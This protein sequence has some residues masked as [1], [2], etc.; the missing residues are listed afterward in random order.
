MEKISTRVL[1]GVAAVAAA[2]GLTAVSAAA[3]AHAA[4]GQRVS[5]P[6]ASRPLAASGSQL[7]LRHFN[8]PG[9]NADTARAMAVSP[10]GSRVFITGNSGPA[11]GSPSYLT[12]AYNALTGRQLWAARY[13]DPRHGFDAANAVAV[14]PSGGTVF[15]TG[16][17][18][19]ARDSA[20]TYL[21]IAY[22]SS[23]GRQR[24]VARYSGNGH[25]SYDAWHVGGRRPRRWQG[26]RDRPQRRDQLR[27]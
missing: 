15:V 8:G 22:N 1:A 11:N 3:V 7:W 19:P 24:W 21:T 14:G 5:E 13:N 20:S 2:V 27:D 4:G 17:S 25:G 9:S 18:R 26:F 6:P 12:V 10:D 23:T 16:L